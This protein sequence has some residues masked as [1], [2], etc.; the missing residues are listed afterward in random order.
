SAA[1]DDPFDMLQAIMYAQIRDVKCRPISCRSPG[2]G[3][4]YPRMKE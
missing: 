2:P 3:P 4:T 1:W